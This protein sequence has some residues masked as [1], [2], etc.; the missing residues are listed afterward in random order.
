MPCYKNEYFI[1]DSDSG[2]KNDN[3]IISTFKFHIFFKKLRYSSQNLNTKKVSRFESHGGY[4][5][6]GRYKIIEEIY[7][8]QKNDNIEKRISI[9]R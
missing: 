6:K 8:S 1:T 4:L 9:S 3:I 2:K 7:Y 5:S